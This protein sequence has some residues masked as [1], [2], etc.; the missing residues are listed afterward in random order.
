MSFIESLAMFVV[1]GLTTQAPSTIRDV[2]HQPVQPK[3]GTMVLITARMPTGTTK[4]T[5]KLQAIAP[6]KYVRKSDPAYEQE[7][8]DLPMRDDGQEGDAKAGDG[9]F[10]VR[11]PASWQR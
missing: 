9:I 4:A 1:A 3:P 5:L 10:S 11:V 7:W 6:G 2:R 8:T